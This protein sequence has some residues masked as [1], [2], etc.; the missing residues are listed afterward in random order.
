[1]KKAI[2]KT[3]KFWIRLVGVCLVVPILVFTTAL[4][5][6]SNN[7]ND[8]V[9]GQVGS[10][11]EQFQGQIQVGETHLA[12]F[13][14]FP[15]MSLI[16]NDV[17]VL[18]S[19]SASSGEIL[20]VKDIYLGLDIL[21]LVRGKI[22]IKKFKVENGFIDLV[23]HD[24]GSNNLLN[25]FASE[26][27]NTENDTTA[28]NLLDIHLNALEI[29]NLA[30]HK[31]DESSGLDI[32]TDIK[33]AKGGFTIIN[34][35]I[36][37]FIDSDFE[38]NLIQNGDTS[39][40]NHKH[41]ELHAKVEYNQQTGILNIEPSSL[42]MET[43][44]FD[45]EGDIDTQNEMD[46][47]IELKG[48]KAN[49]D[50]FIAFAPNELIPILERYKNEGDIYFST[51]VYGPSTFGKIPLINA[52]FGADQ[53]YLE[54]TLNNRKVDDLGF[55]GY[56]TNGADRNLKTMQ[57]ALKNLRARLDE[58]DFTADLLVKNFEE[59]DIEMLID[60]DFDL[61]FI[62][63]FLSL[64]EYEDVTGA[65]ELKMKFHDIIDLDFPERTLDNLERAYYSELS[66]KDFGVKTTDLPA[67]LSNLN[68][69]VIM[70][71]KE[72]VIEN[73]SGQLGKSDIKISGMLSDFPSVVHQTGKAVDVKLNIVSQMLDI[74]ELT[75]YSQ[76]DSIGVNEQ[77]EDLRMA[78]TFKSSAKD[79]IEFENLPVGEFYID[80]LH[81][82]MKHYPHEFHDFHA[83]VLVN[84]LDLVIKDFTGEIDK[85]DFNFNGNVHHYDFWFKD[86]LDGLVDVD[87][88]IQS[89]QLKLEDLLSYE[90]VNY[91]PKEYQHE[92]LD[93]LK[94]HLNA[95]MLY[96][97][98]SLESIEVNLDRFDA[99]MKLH[100][101]KFKNFKGQFTY[102]N[103]HIYVEDFHAELGKSNFN[104][105]L[106]YYLGDN[107]KSDNVDNKLLLKTNFIDFD[108]LTNF[109]LSPTKEYQIGEIATEQNSPEL[110][111]HEDAFNIY[112]L[113]FSKMRFDVEVDQFIYHRLNIKNIDA[114][115]MTTPNHYLYVDTLSMD[116]AGG[117][118]NMNGY[119]NG[120]DSENIYLKPNLKVKHV[121]LDELLFKF[122]NFGQDAIVSENLHGQLTANITG[123]IR[124]YPDLVPDLDQS[125]IHM[126][127]LAIDGRLENYDYMLMLSDYFGDKNLANVKF[128]T[129]Q[130]HIDLTNGVLSIPKMT[131][132]STLGHLEIS[133]KQDLEDNI[134]YYVR[135]PWSMIR[136]GARSKLFSKKDNGSESA[137][138]NEIVEFDP[139]DKIRYLNLKIT[140]TL[141]E[142]KIR[143]GKDKG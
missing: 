19:K 56:F 10:L 132:E 3:R 36:K 66:V 94:V 62:A 60:A 68:A 140:G 57:F 128:D 106:D 80:N 7:Q 46:I 88:N 53:A 84:D 103:E 15:Y 23:L 87:L 63:E 6:L 31:K 95:Q 143:A 38:L 41:F 52:K 122:E 139:K 28:P 42:T 73:I 115:L 40:F 102:A 64:D 92:E 134:E 24:D 29:N 18:E 50:M 142:F 76:A 96:S 20:H 54:N 59:P 110:N 51:R 105:E 58:G 43:A 33:S 101:L 11:N 32:E 27:E 79:L 78:F 69:H 48:S 104:I 127:V 136:S 123:N 100:P 37:A 39:Y 116:I 2:W 98:N 133:G 82:Q 97:V 77:I 25:A 16:I 125:E 131:I 85:S 119:F 55:E 67:A 12:P 117:S 22:D 107:Y 113:P 17:K 65:V 81:A 14:N 9:Q 90:G 108:E 138:E 89:N 118:L 86:T 21:D 111:E 137:T 5:Y 1:M 72:A 4:I 135:I 26:N 93:E 99:K 91:V 13:D 70:E 121:N 74:A 34:D 45:F 114:K 8:L 44:S 47:D 112:E 30:V 120:N 126:D 49:F 35:H 75:A 83:D 141:D 61:G 109:N 71:G 130:N 124:V 129:L